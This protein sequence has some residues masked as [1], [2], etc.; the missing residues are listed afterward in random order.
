VQAKIHWL[1]DQIVGFFKWL[2]QQLVGG[3]IIPDL[4]NGIITWFGKLPGAIGAIFGKLI[5]QASGWGSSL[6]NGFLSGLQAAWAGLMAWVNQALANLAAM[7]PHSPVKEG[8][9]KGSEK[10]G[11]NF[12]KNIADGMVAGMPLVQSA[13]AGLGGGMGNLGISHSFSGPSGIASSFGGAP[14]IHVH[15]HNEGAPIYLDGRE[16]AQGIGPH[17]ASIVRVQSGRRTPS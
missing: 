7:F 8:P 11:Y 2:W 6:I 12:M 14:V 1:V 5:A 3:S 4:V 16:L 9:L 10:W 15:V 13:L 17:I